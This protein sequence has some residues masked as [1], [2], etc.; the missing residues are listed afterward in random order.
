[1]ISPMLLEKAI[2][3]INDNTY[4]TELKLDGI[5]L[6]WTKFNDKVR[7]YTRHNTE[8]TFRFKELHDLDMPNGTILDGEL[9][10]PGDDGKPEFELMMERFQSSKS[11]HFIQYCVF[12]II[13]YNDQNVTSLPL[14]ERKEL[15]SKVVTPIEHVVLGQFIQGHAVE[16]F[17][18]VKE[19]D[20]E[21]IVIKKADSP[22]ELNKRSK[23]WIKVINYQYE[24][25]Y[26]TAL[27]KGEFGVNL[28]FEDGS[29]AGLMEFMPTDERKKLY[30]TM[31]KVSETEKYIRIEPIK[32]QVKYRNLTRSGL[33]RIPSFHQW[34]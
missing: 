19:R 17:D 28:A 7:L 9:I 20:L 23:T 26:L 10:V 3:P 5:R 22:Y 33:L 21:G 27:K 14:L 4:L 31:R 29:Y 12:D 1:M 8:V 30:Q 34:L 15:L 32:C 25:I 11:N 2:E 6:I 24:N 16:Y 13:Q 18:L